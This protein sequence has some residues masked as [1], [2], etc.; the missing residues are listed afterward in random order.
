[1]AKRVAVCV[2]INDYPGTS[3]DLSGCVNDAKD[4]A[5]LLKNQF[6]FS[7]ITMLLDR[8]ATWSKVTSAL[9]S[10]IK[11]SNK[12]DS[13]VFTYSGH[14]SSVPD[15]DGDEPDGRDEVLC[16][17]DKFL[18]DD[19]LR[20]IIGQLKDGVKLTIIS[21]SCHSGTV[22]RAQL[23]KTTGIWATIK[24]FFNKKDYKRARYMPPQDDKVAM[25]VAR[26]PLKGRIFSTEGMKDVLVTGCTSTEYSYDAHINGKYNGAMTYHAIQ[27]VKKNPNASYNDF[28][29][30]LRKRLPSSQ[31][32]QTP[33]LEGSKKNLA[34]KLFTL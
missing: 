21:D 15:G 5:S 14:G 32:P 12:G 27:S 22:T 18:V 7:N 23:P 20:N 33:Q 17:Y 34:N 16:L 28:Y 19:D 8:N 11:N 26:L 31:Y 4:W 2:G 25:L 3:N 10:M 1:M 6:Q 24:K 9:Q 29:A 30:E 13:L